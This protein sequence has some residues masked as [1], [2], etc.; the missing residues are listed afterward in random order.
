MCGGG[1]S[2]FRFDFVGILLRFAAVVEMERQGWGF[3][4]SLN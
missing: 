2:L 3:A 4:S 1:G